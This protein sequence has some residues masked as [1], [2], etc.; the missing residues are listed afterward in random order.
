[1]GSLGSSQTVS[2]KV[3]CPQTAFKWASRCLQIP[4]S[5]VH[6][7]ESQTDTQTE[8]YTAFRLKIFPRGLPLSHKGPEGMLWASEWGREANLYLQ[9]VESQGGTL[10]SLG[11]GWGRGNR[12]P[13]AATSTEPSGLG[14]GGVKE[15]RRRD[16]PRKLP[17][18][19]A[20]QRSSRP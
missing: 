20:L 5:C 12:R 11:S 14:G 8:T 15:A 10:L 9:E 3:N 16:Q 1:M 19:P 2:R 13:S 17:P 4:S 7:G 6:R 18:S